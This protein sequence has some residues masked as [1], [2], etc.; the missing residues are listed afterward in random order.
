MQDHA[1]C[2]KF[3]LDRTGH[4]SSPFDFNPRPIQAIGPALFRASR[5]HM[6]ARAGSVANAI[7]GSHSGGNK[8]KNI[9]FRRQFI[10]FREAALVAAQYTRH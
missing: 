8:P 9:G 7:D 10:L 2:R 1:L 3:L 5:S 4:I 6:Q